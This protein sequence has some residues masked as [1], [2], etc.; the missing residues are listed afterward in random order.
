MKE[1]NGRSFKLFLIF[2][3]GL[4]SFTLI[5]TMISDYLFDEK[6]RGRGQ[7]TL[8]EF[9]TMVI[10]LMSIVYLG[11]EGILKSDTVAAL[12]GAIGGYILGS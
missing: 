2:I 3:G 12:L 1:E 5:G 7:S 4:I 8:M 10:I 9:F 6:L 11:K